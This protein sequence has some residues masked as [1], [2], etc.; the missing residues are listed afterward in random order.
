M[1]RHLI[2][3]VIS[4]LISSNHAFIKVHHPR[5]WQRSLVDT[6]TSRNIS[7]AAPP[8]PQMLSSSSPFTGE[9]TGITNI[10]LRKRRGISVS[11][12]YKPFSSDTTSTDCE[13]LSQE[14]RKISK[15]SSIFAADVQIISDLA[16]EQ[17]TAK[18]NFPGPCPVIFN[19]RIEDA[20]GAIER[21]ADAVVVDACDIDSP[22][23]KKVDIICRVSSAD[24]VRTLLATGF[25]HAF[26]LPGTLEDDELA[27][28]LEVLPEE[29]LVLASLTCMQDDSAEVSRGKELSRMTAGPS[30]ATAKISGLLIEGA[31]VGDAE[32]VPYTSFVVESIGKKSS[33]VFRMSGLTGA[34][35]GHFGS[36]LSGG[37]A[38]AKW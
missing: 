16:K 36:E 37:N 8:V 24:Q 32:D 12:E 6:R 1:L 34:A 22:Q 29:A 9:A 2:F 13:L 3:T 27:A 14:L 15:T 20:N 31:C 23:I 17:K 11:V 28:I 18:G 4:L 35:N 33:S 21:G 7:S 38:S 10:S 30:G 26:L 5:S 25:K 19:G